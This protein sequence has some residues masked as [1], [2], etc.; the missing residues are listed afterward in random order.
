MLRRL[1]RVHNLLLIGLLEMAYLFKFKKKKEMFFWPPKDGR[2]Y[3][4]K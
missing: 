1:P 2:L 3:G 4:M